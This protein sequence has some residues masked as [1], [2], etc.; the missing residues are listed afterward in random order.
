MELSDIRSKI[1]DIDDELAALYVKRMKLAGEAA[2]IKAKSDK[3]ITDTTREREIV[4][5]LAKKVPAEFT[6]YLKELYETVF[7]TSKAYQ[8]ALMGR[9]SKT[10]ERLEDIIEKGLGNMPVSA[11]VA[12]QGINGANSGAAAKKFFSL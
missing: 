11:T 12:C 4:F 2:E 5:R 9:S 3:S 10:V 7:F 6:L 1:D 8:S